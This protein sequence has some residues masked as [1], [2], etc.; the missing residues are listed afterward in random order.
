MKYLE[1]QLDEEQGIEPEM[2]LGRIALIGD[3]G[4]IED[5]NLMLDTF[6]EAIITGLSEVRTHAEVR[7]DTIDE[8]LDLVLCRR[9]DGIQLSFGPQTALIRDEPALRRE[10]VAAVEN[11]LGRLDRAAKLQR[12]KPDSARVLERGG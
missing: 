3:D 5:D 1:W 10:L 2:P 8:P 11:L 9:P 6:L 12:N 4:R 7:V